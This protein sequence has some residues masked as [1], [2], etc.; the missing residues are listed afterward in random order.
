MERKLSTIPM[1]DL[2]KLAK[3][4]DIS[5]YYKLNRHD[6]EKLVLEHILPKNPKKIGD[7]VG[8]TISNV[9]IN[10]ETVYIYFANLDY[11][12]SLEASSDCC[13]VSFLFDYEGIKKKLIGTKFMSVSQ[14]TAIIN[15]STVLK[16]NFRDKYVHI[17]SNNYTSYED[18]EQVFQITINNHVALYRIDVSNGYY[19]GFLHSSVDKLN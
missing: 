2:R 7:L 12:L 9:I 5:G 4:E 15:A 10:V 19:S 18:Y 14:E 17:L 16:D 3:S 13:D 11:R 8:R 6:L 1:E